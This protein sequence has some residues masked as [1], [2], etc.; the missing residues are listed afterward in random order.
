M[1]IHRIV[2][3]TAT[4]GVILAI[5]A[6]AKGSDLGG[7]ETS[8]GGAGGAGG[9]SQV[10]SGG[11]VAVGGRS[12]DAG[13]D[14]NGG[15]TSA[16]GGLGQA[17]AIV[18][19]RGGGAQA[20]GSGNAGTTGSGQGGNG[21]ASQ[22]DAPVDGLGIH[23][24]P[25]GDP[26]TGSINLNMKLEN[27]SG[28]AVE[29]TTVTIHYYFTVDGWSSPVAEKYYVSGTGVVAPTPDIVEMEVGEEGADHY[30]E[31]SFTA[32]SLA[33]NGVLEFQGAIH[34]VDWSKDDYDQ[35]ND[36]SFTQLVGYN[37]RI[38]VY[39]SGALSWGVEPGTESGS[40][41]SGGA[42]GAGGAE[43]GGEAGAPAGEGG[44]TAGEAGATAAAGTSAEA[45]TSSEAGATSELGGTP[46]DA[47]SSGT[48]EGGVEASAGTSSAA[49]ST[50]EPEGLGGSEA[51][52]GAANE[53]GAA[54]TALSS[55]AW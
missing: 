6:C 29:L 44:S 26:T 50:G 41:G 33:N 36:Y 54:G 5:G 15:T 22:V 3:R 16:A 30:A 32:G 9:S 17:G 52:A 21:G 43:S 10:G 45:G 42:D 35:T 1:R 46:A 25:S 4:L 34:D 13:E 8:T 38:T 23:Q 31:I 37:D 24:T 18:I 51:E 48:E 53:A 12:A 47:G 27:K 39:V 19:S 20:G 11:R 14:T 55:L 28:A 40:G 2:E 7:N 49:G